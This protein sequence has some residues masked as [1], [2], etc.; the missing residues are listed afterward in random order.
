M[1]QFGSIN[2][3]V[4]D[5]VGLTKFLEALGV[6][7][8]PIDPGWESWASHHRSFS[9]ADDVDADLDSSRFASDW[10]GMPAGYQGVV[11]NLKTDDRDAV[12]RAHAIAIE[13]GGSSRKAPHDAFWGSRYAVIESPFGIAFGL[14]SPSDPARRTATTFTP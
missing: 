11:V 1:T 12:D 8:A 9:A 7:I 2:I 14:M 4:D 13:R 5:V 10:G 6:A 3:V